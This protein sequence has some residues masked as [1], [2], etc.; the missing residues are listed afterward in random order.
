MQKNK[1][2]S[3]S[4]EVQLKPRDSTG[5]TRLTA[6]QKQTADNSQHRNVLFLP[7]SY[8]N[9]S[10]SSD[11]RAGSR[12]P[13]DPLDQSDP[14]LGFH[15]PERLLF[16]PLHS[17]PLRSA[18]HHTTPEPGTDSNHSERLTH[19]FGTSR[20]RL[21]YDSRTVSRD[22][23]TIPARSRPLPVQTPRVRRPS[24]AGRCGSPPCPAGWTTTSRRRR[25]RWAASPSA[26]ERRTAR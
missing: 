9:L 22:S 23:R 13:S 1:Q 6:T 8:L 10:V 3:W 15:R 17:T 12:D 5:R 21:P 18:P 16:S 2:L 19:V 25:R 26:S 7:D 24:A 11:H 14:S 4:A 20:A